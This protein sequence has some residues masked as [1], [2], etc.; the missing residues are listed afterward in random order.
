MTPH[1]N[2]YTHALD[3]L[4]NAI[5][6]LPHSAGVMRVYTQLC[7][8]D[9]VIQVHFPVTM[10]SGDI[11]YFEGYRVQY[12]NTLGPYKGGIRFHSQVDIDEVKALAFWMTIKC[13]VI[14][15]PMGGGKGGVVVD[16]KKLSKN[17]LERLS[18]AYI[19]AI[20][21]TIGSTRDIP[22]PDVNTNATIMSW[23]MKE[24]KHLV[25]KKSI[26]DD[27]PM[28]TFTGKHLQDHGSLGREAA[29]G[30]GGAIVLGEILRLSNIKPRTLT[31]AIQ[32]YGNVGYYTAKFLTEMG[33]RVI[34][35]SDSRGA[36][37]VPN[38]INP[39]LTLQ[40]KHQH[41]TISGC[42]C[43]GSVCNLK[44]GKSINPE[45]IITLPVDIL[46]PAALEGVITATSAKQIKA[47]YILEMANGP[48]TP[49]GELVLHKRD[50][51]IIPDVL[52]N[53]GG[54]TVSCFEWMQ[55]MTNQ[56]W[57]EEKV[58]RKLRTKLISA[59]RQIYTLAQMQ[60]TSLREA[61][62]ALAL[63]HLAQK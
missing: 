41:G 59:T 13:A 18:K 5:D 8:P 58:F 61:A 31:A 53:A 39:D 49:E 25:R 11:H 46:V 29:T 43:T 10:D 37:V 23:M 27:H 42:Y 47:R 14:N 56:R 51:I 17:E 3:Q 4:R 52:A 19:R 44:N 33:I 34:A 22:A 20:A 21:P 1:P 28:A 16:P 35:V 30:K 45:D 62:F 60:Q 57:S 12:N 36:V 38:G 55:N 2:P 9:R 40:C 32:G 15:L 54:V 63:T 7:N 50:T 6:H 24:Y 26:H 48:T